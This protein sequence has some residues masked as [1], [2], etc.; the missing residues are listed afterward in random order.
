M[1]CPDWRSETELGGED[2]SDRMSLLYQDFTPVTL[3]SEEREWRGERNLFRQL[4]WENGE[5]KR[6]DID[7][8][9]REKETNNNQGQDSNQSP[10]LN[11]QQT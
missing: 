2:T 9:K 3:L 10:S 11:A 7:V 8:I 5:E 1:S 4:E 6:N